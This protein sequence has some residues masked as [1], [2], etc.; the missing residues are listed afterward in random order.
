MAI[1]FLEGTLAFIGILFGA[2]E[3]G[4]VLRFSKC[5]CLLRKSST[6][7]NETIKSSVHQIIPLEYLPKLQKMRKQSVNNTK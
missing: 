6:L 1:N 2:I 3:R 7:L 4:D 5:P